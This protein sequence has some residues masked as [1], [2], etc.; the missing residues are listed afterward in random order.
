MPLRTRAFTAAWSRISRRQL[1]RWTADEIAERR[2]EVVPSRPPYTWVTGAVPKGVRITT[3]EVTL[4]D[5]ATMPARVVR[6]DGLPPEAPVVVYF[7]GGGW[8]LSNPSNYD[9]LTGF[10]AAEL[11]A[12]VVA[13]DYRKAPQAKAPQATLDAYDTLAWVAE[14][15]EV[16]AASGPIAVAG[17]SAGG[18][19]AALVSILSRDL[20][21]PAIAGQA[22]LYPATDLTRSHPSSHWRQ[23]AILS[24]ESMDAYLAAY[25]DGASV[26]A[27]NPLVSPLFAASHTDLPPC[28]LQ[29]AECDPLVDEGEHYGLVLQ[30][31]GVPTRVTRYAGMPHGFMSFPSIT[32]VGRQAR[33]ELVTC[34]R[35]WLQDARERSGVGEVEVGPGRLLP[36]RD[37]AADH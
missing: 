30:A 29:T 36:D 35:A 31:A 25:L 37:A 5:G 34:L 1:A 9:P 14:R 16:L 23:E 10:L 21:G 6:P 27:E 24:G 32:P 33:T 22:L 3:T 17:D 26:S 28:L 13:P 4:R 2:S 15:P 11:G 19:L 20:D 7:H 8:T 18:N 12:V